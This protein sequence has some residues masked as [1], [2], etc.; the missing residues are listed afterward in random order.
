LIIK[1]KSTEYAALVAGVADFGDIALVGQ[2]RFWRLPTKRLEHLAADMSS[3]WHGRAH[4]FQ[5]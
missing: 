1:I 3:H 4:S 2:R 5:Q